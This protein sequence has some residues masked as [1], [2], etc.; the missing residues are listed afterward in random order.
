MKNS[1]ISEQTKLCNDI[2]T[3]AAQHL[4]ANQVLVKD[5]NLDFVSDKTIQTE[6]KLF[7]K[8]ISNITLR[9]S[10]IDHAEF[11][12]SSGV[13]NI[14]VGLEQFWRVSPSGKLYT[15]N[16]FKG[17]T[18][19][20]KGIKL[21]P[22]VEEVVRPKNKLKALVLSL[23]KTVPGI[24]AVLR[25]GRDLF[26]PEPQVDLSLYEGVTF[27]LL[28]SSN[29]HQNY[30]CQSYDEGGIYDEFVNAEGLKYPAQVTGNYY[31]DSYSCLVF[32]RL[33][34]QTHDEKWLQASL[35]SQRFTE[36]VYPQYMPAGIV[37]HHSDFKNAAILEQILTSVDKASCLQ[38]W[39]ITHFFEDRYEPT[40]VFALRYH[41]KSLL[42]KLDPDNVMSQGADDDLQ[43]LVADQTADGLFHDNI[44]TYPDAHD[45]TYHQY[46][47]ACL[48]MGLLQ[49]NNPQGWTVF[50]HAVRFTLQTLSPNGE[51]A[52]TGRASNNIHQS[53]SAILAF[54]IA[55]SNTDDSDFAMVLLKG[56]SVVAKRLKQFQL[57]SGMLPTAM[58]SYVE[59]RMGW[60]HC[61]TPYNSLVAFMLLKAESI[62]IKLNLQGRACLLPLENN[63]MW[64]ANDAGFASVSNGEYYLVCF[65]GCDRSYGWSEEKHVTGSAGIALFGEV[66]SDSILPCL[67]VNLPDEVVISDMPIING[68]AA[69]GRGNLEKTDDA[70][71]YTHHYG[72]ANVTR[73][74][75]FIDNDLIIISNIK[76]LGPNVRVNGVMAWAVLHT[77]NGK[78]ISCEQNNSLMISKGQH[79]QHIQVWHLNNSDIQGVKQSKR[80]TNAKGMAS[81]FEFGSALVVEQ[82]S[83]LIVSSREK[84]SEYKIYLEED[85]VCIS[86]AK[87]IHRSKV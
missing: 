49:S 15:L 45:L 81:R 39:N 34:I 10:L 56:I 29:G 6:F 41:W 25:R 79:Q 86:H 20:H 50:Y 83:I 46:S 3:K 65:A 21:A 22:I 68:Q 57:E 74:Y 43:R 64:L 27:R 11:K 35:A 36:R 52:Y 17:R 42:N 85:N 62:L 63:A 13:G 51:P 84:I 4:L 5:L 31:A 47:T 60:N 44:A 40:N 14:R 70:I 80:V 33:Y 19:S 38:P 67:D 75:L 1:F 9:I 7:N 55:A 77:D 8:S 18:P 58:N 61:H 66:N 54:S 26:F 30:I 28:P 59:L 2:A 82:T 16:G 72:G 23:L 78:E 71:K 76:A 32:E 24:F 37:W 87:G 69:F 48:G 73:Y 53:A 12:V